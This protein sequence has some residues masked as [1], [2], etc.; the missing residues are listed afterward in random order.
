MEWEG[1]G[2]WECERGIEGEC[3]REGECGREE[4][5]ECVFVCE[6]VGA[7]DKRLERD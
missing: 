7:S 1:E 6:V 5:W 2:E 3:E 4:E